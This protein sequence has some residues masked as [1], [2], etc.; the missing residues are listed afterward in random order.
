MNQQPTHD[1]DETTTIRAAL[2]EAAA[3][4][5]DAGIP[6][7]RREAALLLADTLARDRAYLI[8]HHDAQP[9]TYQ[10]ARFRARVRRRAAGEPAQYITGSQ[11]FYGLDFEVTP[12]VLIPRPE[13]ELL[14]EI[15][16][17]LLRDERAPH[18]C[19]VGTGSGCIAVTLLH[20]RTDA[21]ALALDASRAA[22]RVAARNAARHGVRERLALIASDCF[23]ALNA[24]AMPFALIASNPPYISAAE[25]PHLQREVRDHEPHMALTPGDADGLA[26]IR[27]LLVEAPAYLRPGGH[28]LIEIGHA[29]HE[30]V[31][32]LVNPRVWTLVAI[33]PDLQ[34]IP[35][36][37]VLRRLDAPC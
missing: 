1:A 5:R 23:S 36:T 4:L 35:R 22:L 3:A 18:L 33:R 6:D 27:R 21:R 37:V 25:V 34:N 14:V 20:E 30:P 15:A 28:L 9:D 13:T 16:L 17:E 2:A 31:A 32:R 19:D 29:Q 7:A 24:S 26:I 11:E 8:T 12:D 10:L